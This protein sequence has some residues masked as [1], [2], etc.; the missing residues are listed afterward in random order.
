MLSYAVSTDGDDND[1]GGSYHLVCAKHF[2]R[3]FSYTCII[4][5]TSCYRYF[6]PILDMR[7]LAHGGQLFQCPTT[8]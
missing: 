1:N 7:D 5:M 4:T 6:T 3:H 8:K 2:G